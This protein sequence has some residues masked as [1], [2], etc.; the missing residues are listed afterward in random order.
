MFIVYNDVTRMN[1]KPNH[2]QVRG[3]VKISKKYFL[4]T[5][6]IDFVLIYKERQNNFSGCNSD[7]SKLRS[8]FLKIKILSVGMVL[9][10]CNF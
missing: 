7:G 3:N 2:K 6:K 8:A 1:F 5:L 4:R 10:R 9:W